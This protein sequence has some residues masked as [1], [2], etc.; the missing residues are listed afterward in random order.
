MAMAVQKGEVPKELLEAQKMWEQG[1]DKDGN[2]LV[3]HEG[4]CIIEPD[5]GFVVK[6]VD[7]TG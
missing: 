4:G 5:P 1:K 6:T 2:P 3:D 7:T